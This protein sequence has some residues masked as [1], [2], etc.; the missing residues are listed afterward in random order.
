MEGL[1][2]LK[3]LL[4]EGDRMCKLDLKDGYFSVPLHNFSKKFMRFELSGNLY[5]FLC[6]CFG[7]VLA[8]RIFTKLLK[9]PMAVLRRLMIR[10]VIYLD[11]M[12]ILGRSREEVLMAR[13]TLIFFLQNLGFLIHLKKSVLEPTQKIEFLLM[14]VNSL[15][16]SL[17]LTKEK[18]A[19]IH[20]QC[21]SLYKAREATILELTQLIGVLSSIIEAVLP[22]RL[23]FC[24]LQQ[25]QIQSLKVSKSYATLVHLRRKSLEELLWWV[26][27]LTLYNGRSLIQPQTQF[28]LQ[29]DAFLNGWG[30]VCQGNRTGGMWSLTE[31]I[32]HI[33]ALELLAIKLALLSFHKTKQFASVHIQTD[34]MTALSYLLKMGGTKNLT[35]IKIAKEIWDFLLLHKIMITAKY[36]PGCLNIKAD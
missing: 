11:D 25:Q 12:L 29:T 13:D 17:Y 21:L 27:N 35:M 34:N 15:T 19:K 30:A 23:E 14:S 4:N 26:N 9:I 22:A 18:V 33:N 32:L 7:F 20:K 1:H 31:Q 24:F 2:S 16:M 6:L 36:L 28:L 10:I 3:F 8:P 5:E